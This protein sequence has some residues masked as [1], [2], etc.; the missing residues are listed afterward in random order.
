MNQLSLH[1]LWTLERTSDGTVCPAPVPGDNVSAL[2]AAGRIPDPYVGLNEV[3]VQWIGKEDWAF[4]RTFTVSPAFLKHE[5][6]VLELESV[7]TVAEYWINGQKAGESQSMFVPVRLAVRPFLKEGENDLRIVLKSAEATAA[8][9]AAALPYP[10][11]HAQ[12]PI[13]SPH[14]NLVRKAQ[15]H[16]GWDWGPCLM[17]S[18]LYGAVR[19]KAAKAA[20]LVR[21]WT[22]TV[23]GASDLWELKV[24]ADVEAV[25]AGK[26]TL[27]VTFDALP[28]VHAGFDLR[29]G[30][31]TVCFSMSVKGPQV[32]NPAGY[33]AQAL[34]RLT[35]GLG[36]DLWEGRV[37][38]R[39]LVWDSKEDEWGKGLTCLV[40][41]RPVF[42]KGANWIPADAL[43]SRATPTVITARLED[44][45]AANMNLIRVWGGGIYESDWFYDECD[46]LGILVWQDFMFGCATYPAA[47]WFLDQVAVEVEHQVKR[48]KAHPCLA[49]FCGNNEDLGAL[50]WFAESKAQPYKYLVDYDRLNEGTIGRIVRQ[51]DGPG[52]WW[53]S[54][55]SGGVDDYTDGWHVQGRGDMHFWS[56]WHE[57]KSFDEY[58]K[59]VP[60]FCS[61]F[62]FQSFP[63]PSD[64]ARYAS[65][66]QW[67][68]TSPVMEH[69]QRNPGG[70]QRIL[71]TFSRYFRVPEGFVNQL[72]LS[73]VQQA[74]AIQTASEYWHACRPRNMGI[75]YWQLN[76]LWPVASWS[77]I[78]VSGRWKV[79]HYA[80]RR[81]FEP[82]HAAGFRLGDG[83]L[84]VV[85]TNDTAT[86]VPGTLTLAWYTAGGNPVA[87]E[88]TKVDVAADSA[89]EV[90]SW[91]ASD[92]PDPA[93]HFLEVTFRHARG[94]SRSTVFLTEPKRMA[95]PDPGLSFTVEDRDGSLEVVV[96]ALRPGFWVTLDQGDLAGRFDDNGVTLLAGE[97][98]RFR[99]IGKKIGAATLKRHLK[100]FDLYSSSQPRTR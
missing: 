56:V 16:S 51:V 20:D 42:A 96:N 91:Q 60:R 88:T 69:H 3:E 97:E 72:Y 71:E 50:T 95:L 15:C 87:T 55:P 18:G 80:A 85:L 38:F 100:L 59:V 11:P 41:G 77:S 33:G 67:N 32:W 47:P 26:Q 31:Q 58:T 28:P 37:G 53:P 89:K 2:L 1:G 4:C 12:F 93:G 76:D 78:T 84:K 98:R 9:L 75:V 39:T 54:S 61:E 17:V 83:S 35:V 24:W 25:R 34:Y 92:L 10:I 64:V 90:R 40:N 65:P 13:Q 5:H 49:L 19:L 63:W 43:P 62:G 8:A 57:G 73:Q 86:A 70:N 66:D 48:L 82:V 46:R 29:V 99:W 68:L 22:E 79:L 36:G 81:F 52:R 6:I 14:R 21:V 7:D 30:T 44:A 27:S 94:E 45:V 74:L 23:P